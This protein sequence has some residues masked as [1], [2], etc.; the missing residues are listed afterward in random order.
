MKASDFYN[1]NISSEE[2][3]RID[4]IELFDE[5][6]PWHLKCT[7]Y[8]L[9]SATKGDFC[10]KMVH[11][12]Y[13]SC[14]SP[15]NLLNELLIIRFDI[16]NIKLK[17]FPIKFGQRFGLSVCSLGSKLFVFGGF[18][19][20]ATDQLGKHLR[21]PYIEVVDL[22]RMSLKVLSLESNPICNN[23]FTSKTF[24]LSKNII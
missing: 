24:K 16:E 17:P 20:L 4:K 6:E 19:E 5:Y 23:I 12:L 13:E 1:Y 10:T 7:H 11:D 2:K 14:K 18:G 9:L 15:V 8:T 22:S 3:L 21:L